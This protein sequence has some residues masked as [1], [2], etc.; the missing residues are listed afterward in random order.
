MR[1]VDIVK[2]PVLLI[3]PLVQ[4]CGKSEPTRSEP[5]TK[6]LSSGPVLIDRGDESVLVAGLG[7]N[8]PEP[9]IVSYYGS[10]AGKSAKIITHAKDNE[11]ILDQRLY[12]DGNLIKSFGPKSRSIIGLTKLEGRIGTHNY[13]FEATDND[14]NTVRTKTI[15]INYSGETD[16]RLPE[17]Y[18]FSG[19]GDRAYEKANLV[20]S[21]Q[22]QGDN[23]GFNSVRLYED[24]KEV[25]D[26][27]RL[28]EEDLWIFSQEVTH[29]T[30]GKHTY[31]LEVE[32]FGGHKVKSKEVTVEFNPRKK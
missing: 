16:D 29:S 18:L 19:T 7:I 4:G 13:Y 10:N 14:G 5:S 15:K 23:V 2:V 28:N 1:L 11:D 21:V 6:T 22:D 17:A 8:P 31:H 26:F 27:G 12:E 3:A 9:E 24:G 20:G 30:F 32:D 25:R